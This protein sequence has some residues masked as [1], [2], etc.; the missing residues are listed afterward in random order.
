VHP[1]AA[2]AAA[3]LGTNFDLRSFRL[4][5]GT[6]LAWHLGHRV[7]EDL[8]FFSFIPDTLDDAGSAALVAELQ[9]IQPDG[10]PFRSGERTVHGSVGACRVSFFEITGSWLAPPT[11]VADAMDLATVDEIAS[12]KLIAVMTRCAKKDFF[13]LAAIAERGMTMRAMVDAGRRM[14]PGFDQALDHLR[15]AM[16]YFDEAELDP[17]PVLLT[18]MRWPAVKTAIRS[19]AGQI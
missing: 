13:D 6:A 4:A 2:A 12:M 10:Q 17:D 15:R 11:R 7:S 3:V 16:V 9:R 18:P 19:L 1:A 8:D 5:G 14:F